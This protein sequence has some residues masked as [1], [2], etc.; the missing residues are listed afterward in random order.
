MLANVRTENFPGPGWPCDS[1][2]HVTMSLSLSNVC[3]S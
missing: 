2:S 3:R 1:S